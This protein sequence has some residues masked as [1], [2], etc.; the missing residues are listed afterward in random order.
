MPYTQGSRLPGET[1]SKL[2]H[3]AVVRSDWVKSLVHEFE[4]SPPPSSDPTK[5]P[6]QDFD[7]T[8]ITALR[9]V[10]A[11]DGS[12]VTVVSESN[13]PREVSFVK[14]ALMT[15]DRARLETIDK[16]HP[17]PLLLQDVLTGS[18]IFHAT[19]LPLKNV[20]TPLGTNY[21]AVRHIVRDS[22]K[23]DDVVTV[24]GSLAKDGSRL[25][26]AR[27]VVMTKTNQRLFA[28]SSDGTVAR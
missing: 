15:V 5:T 22:M 6:W 14:T 17:H 11:V 25:V 19:V 12:F 10:W 21:D 7:P 28:G 18:A 26:N 8:G 13:P 3:L 4:V 9:S 27:S 20:R 1:A 16:D 2:G 23:I 24:D